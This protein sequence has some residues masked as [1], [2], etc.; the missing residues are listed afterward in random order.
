MLV[1]LP[2][3][4]AILGSALAANPDKPGA[5]PKV[6]YWQVNDE[7]AAFLPKAPSAEKGYW[8]DGGLPEGCRMVITAKGMNPRDFKVFNVKYSDCMCSSVRK[9]LRMIAYKVL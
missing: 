9:Y 5:S 7:I 6:P 8:L 1:K 4:A 3:I 2:V